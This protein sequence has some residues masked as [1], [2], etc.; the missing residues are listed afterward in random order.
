MLGIRKIAAVISALLII[1][2]AVYNY[3]GFEAQ[4]VNASDISQEA[5][6]KVN[7]VEKQIESVS[8]LAIALSVSH[9]LKQHLLIYGVNEEEADIW[10]P[11]PQSPPMTKD[12]RYISR[13]PFYMA[14]KLPMLGIRCQIVP[15][16]QTDSSIIILIDTVFDLRKD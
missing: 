2:V 15:K 14:E 7:K 10:S 16:P 12:G 3:Y 1:S 6:R 8:E 11:G 9:R 13:I 5:I 4:I